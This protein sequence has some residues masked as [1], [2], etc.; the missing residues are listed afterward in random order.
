M[1]IT[2]DTY[3]HANMNARVC[4]VCGSDM[5]RSKED[6]PRDEQVEHC[7]CRN[8]ECGCEQTFIN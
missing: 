2:C 5:I 4:P 6:V 1:M 3:Q 8:P 7:T